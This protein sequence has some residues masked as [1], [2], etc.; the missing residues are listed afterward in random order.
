[1]KLQILHNIRKAKID[2]KQVFHIQKVTKDHFIWQNKLLKYKW[3]HFEQESNNVYENK[4]N[5]K[6]RHLR[7]HKI[8]TTSEAF[9]LLITFNYSDKY[10]WPK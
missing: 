7:K 6:T 2:L 10:I 3:I 4:H 8:W 5:K 9:F 1:M